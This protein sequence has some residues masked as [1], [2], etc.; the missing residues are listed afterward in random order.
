MNVHDLEA[1]G[2][3]LATVLTFYDSLPPVRVDE[4]IGSWRGAEIPTGNP[5]DGLLGASGWYGKRFISSEQAHPLVMSGRSGQFTVNPTVIPM[6]FAARFSPVL[7][8]PVVAT[9]MRAVLPLIRT[10][11]PAARLRM[12]EYRGVVSGTMIYDALPAN[13]HFRSIDD[14]TLLGVMDL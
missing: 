9:V 4:M 1:S 5:L 8:L 7:R 11:R 13:D 6:G 14:S 2:A 3:D 10:R 12:V